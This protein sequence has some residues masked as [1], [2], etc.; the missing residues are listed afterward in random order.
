MCFIS[1]PIESTDGWLYEV[2]TITEPE[3]YQVRTT[4]PGG[5]DER[6]GHTDPAGRQGETNSHNGH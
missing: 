4:S 1:R 3:H 2:G 5:T 6:K